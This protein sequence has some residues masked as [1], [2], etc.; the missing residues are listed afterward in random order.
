LKK[1]TFLAAPTSA[2]L[3]FNHL[4]WEQTLSSSYRSARKKRHLWSILFYCTVLYC[5]PAML[6]KSYSVWI[7]SYLKKNHCSSFYQLNPLGSY[8]IL[9]TNL[10]LTKNPN[11][12]PFLWIDDSIKTLSFT[13]GNPSAAKAP[14]PPTYTVGTLLW[15][16]TLS[17]SYRSARKIRVLWSILFYT[18]FDNRIIIVFGAFGRRIRGCLSKIVSPIPVLGKTLQYFKSV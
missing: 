1:S 18:Y 8:I 6:Q 17:S 10:V 5:T 11:V 9:H 13:R 12:V 3:W 2:N 14:R 7:K 15:E 4:L 16:Q